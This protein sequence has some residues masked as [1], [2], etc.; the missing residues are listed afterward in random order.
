MKKFFLFTLI[1]ILVP[2]VL[3]SLFKT[4][5]DLKFKY[6]SNLIIKVKRVNK[7]TIEEIPFEEYVVGV[8]SGEMPASFEVEALKAQAVAARTYALKKM[9]DNY[10]NEYHV[11]DTTDNQVYLDD[12][13]LRLR[14]GETYDG[15]ISK[16][17]KAVYD[18]LGEYLV[19]DNQIID[20]LFFSTSTGVTEN[21]GEIFSN[22]LP[23]LVSVS[24]SF[25]EGVS[26]VYKDSVEMPLST[27][28]T[29]LGLPFKDNVSIEVLETTSTGRIKT[30]KINDNVFSGEEIRIK[31]GLRSNY[32]NIIQINQ[33]IVINTKG[34]GHGVGLSQYGAE[35][36]ALKGYKYDEILKY[37]YTDVDLKKF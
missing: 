24:S 3:I 19:Y 5:P 15:N 11:V 7:G 27:F 26:P 23:Y 21:S 1:I 2:F 9:N 30:I 18:T 12:N 20:A 34:Y 25:E 29:N 13:E 14:W 17:K 32:F 37:Y 4:K 6:G 8:L 36:M 31:L 22:Q 33:I 16:V 35:A 10:E 28:Y